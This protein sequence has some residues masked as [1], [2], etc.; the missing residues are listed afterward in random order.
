[1]NVTKWR[2]AAHSLR[3]EH[4]PEPA[5]W[6][7]TR[8]WGLG[9]LGI[10]GALRSSITLS[11][12]SALSVLSA[13]GCARV[14]PSTLASDRLEYGEQLGES[15]KRQALLNIVRLRHADTPIF[16]D[17]TS[18]INSYSMTGTV[19][20]G[21]VLA[22]SFHPGASFPFGAQN[23]WTN[24]PTVSYMPVTGARFTHNLLSPVPAFSL[25]QLLQAGW[26]PELLFRL[27]VQSVNGIKNP[28]QNPSGEDP[29]FERMVATLA[30]ALQQQALV[31]R[32]DESKGLEAAILEFHPEAGDGAPA[33]LQA[34]RELWRLAPE[35]GGITLSSGASQRNGRDLA[36][37]TRSMLEIMMAVALDM[38]IPAAHL[39]DHSALPS[40]RDPTRK[41]QALIHIQAGRKAPADAYVAARY[42]DSFYW[43]A[44][45]DLVSK[46]RFTFLMILASLAETGVPAAGPVLTLPSR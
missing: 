3:P 7:R 11:A 1:M 20:A 37:L 19:S 24:A 29:R 33:D 27:A 5:A 12:L 10:Q 26:A 30:R 17:V 4:L 9:A 14:Q 38:D 42:R 44:D 39:A 21:A 28:G 16:M 45:T 25:C 18:I 36:M 15:W 31:F 8:R 35:A 40:P 32:M 34:L 13:L 23:S 6:I 41:T 46:E 22:P 2:Q 43:I